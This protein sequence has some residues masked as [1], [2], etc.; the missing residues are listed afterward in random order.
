MTTAVSKREICY[1]WAVLLFCG[2]GHLK[3]NENGVF[4]PPPP[5]TR[6]KLRATPK[7]VQAIRIFFQT[8]CS[9]KKSPNQKVL[10]FT[11]LFL[12]ENFAPKKKQ[13]NPIV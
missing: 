4:T 1:I 9:F 2:H 8:S 6:V 3:E 10:F 12:P 13:S 5:N 11:F 7:V